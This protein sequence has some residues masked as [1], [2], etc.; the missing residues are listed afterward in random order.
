MS[1][2]R[3][4]AAAE[5]TGSGLKTWRRLRLYFQDPRDAFGITSVEERRNDAVLAFVLYFAVKLPVLLQRSAALGHKTPSGLDYLIAIGLALLIGVAMNLFWIGAGGAVVHLVV[6]R[7]LGGR[8]SAA[9]AQRLLAL[10]LTAQLVMV[11]E[12]PTL[13]FGF[14]E[15]GTFLAFTILRNVANVLSARSFYWGLRVLFGVSGRAALA[16]TVLPIVA[17]LVLLLP[18]IL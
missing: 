10:C 3:P 7:V 15:H 12:L 11:A 2:P 5:A 14:R 6:E 8:S 18:Y 17:L 9:E 16:F 1:E 13:A 4:T